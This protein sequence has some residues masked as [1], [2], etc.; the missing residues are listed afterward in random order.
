MPID[1]LVAAVFTRPYIHKY[2]LRLEVPV[3][4]T[5]LSVGIQCT[6]GT[7]VVSI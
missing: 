5:H 7:Y 3:G 1:Y 4:V 2:L 6:K